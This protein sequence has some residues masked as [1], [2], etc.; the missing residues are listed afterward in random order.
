MSEPAWGGF[1]ASVRGPAHVRW[2]LPNQ[3]AW[4]ISC[5]PRAEV[6]VVSDG[7]GSYKHARE[8]ACACCRAV[9]HAVS[10]WA[11]EAAAGPEA[12]LRLVHALWLFLIQPHSP[13]DCHCTCLLALRRDEEFFLAQLGDGMLCVCTEE[14]ASLPFGL[15]EKEFGTATD[16]LGRNFSLRPWKWMFIPA[17]RARGIVLATDGVADDLR[18]EYAGSFACGILD[19]AQA[20]GPE[21]VEKDLTDILTHWPVAGHSDD[22]TIAGIFRR[23]RDA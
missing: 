17:G 22:K 8:G 2:E 11:E 14:E 23:A 10:I 15:P 3:D 5:T 20:D 16:G 6:L 7:M 4:H 9:A 19:T 12:F 13:E 18:E 1:A 21:A